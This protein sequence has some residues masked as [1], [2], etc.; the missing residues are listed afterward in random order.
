MT[1]TDKL[2]C[3]VA[4][5]YFN[6]KDV[7]KLFTSV[8]GS[9]LIHMLELIT[10]KISKVPADER[11]GKGESF[12]WNGPTCKM[13]PLIS[14]IINMTL[15][16]TELPLDT[17]QEDIKELVDVNH[18]SVTRVL[19]VLR[20]ELRSYDRDSIIRVERI[21]EHLMQHAP[22]L[23][24]TLEVD[25]IKLVKSFDAYLMSRDP[26]ALLGTRENH[27]RRMKI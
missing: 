4:T 2:V 8:D 6:H 5:G 18:S 27:I 17:C 3:T 24:G 15:C 16:N 14:F 13:L 20:K 23:S 21:Y 11:K 10:C 7:E 26:R 1:F 22:V 12:L 25:F 9:F 19:V